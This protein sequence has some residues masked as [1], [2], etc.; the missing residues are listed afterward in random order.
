MK[1]YGILLSAEEH[2]EL[3]TIAAQRGVLMQDI[4]RDAVLAAMR[5]QPEAT[6]AATPVSSALQAAH[7]LVK[8]LEI[9]EARTKDLAREVQD[10]ADY[11]RGIINAATVDDAGS[12]TRSERMESA[13]LPTVAPLIASTGRIIV[14]AAPGGGNAARTRPRA[15]GPQRVMPGRRSS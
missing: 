12:P 9:L 13:V 6:P 7:T 14:D 11:I 5:V 3:K 2:K 1:K 4:A 10:A 15:A 8:Q